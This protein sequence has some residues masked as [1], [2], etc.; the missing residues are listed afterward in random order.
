VREF[1]LQSALKHAPSEHLGVEVW[2]TRRLDC[3]VYP[4]TI[5]D[6]LYEKVRVYGCVVSK[7]VL[8]AWG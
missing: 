1:M 6:C 3:N 7:G 8:I 2:R 5:V 4:Y